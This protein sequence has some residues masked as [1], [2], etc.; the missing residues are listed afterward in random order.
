APRRTCSPR[1]WRLRPCALTLPVSL[2]IPA[3]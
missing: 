1:R 2:W 3:C